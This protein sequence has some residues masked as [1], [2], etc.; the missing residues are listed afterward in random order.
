MRIDDVVEFKSSSGHVL[1]KKRFSFPTRNPENGLGEL[2]GYALS[3]IRLMIARTPKSGLGQKAT[4]EN[5]SRKYNYFQT[6]GSGQNISG[7][8]SKSQQSIKNIELNFRM[9]S[10]FVK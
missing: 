9:K 1:L 7:W 4:W 8:K 2:T 10:Y 5:W 6:I 3:T